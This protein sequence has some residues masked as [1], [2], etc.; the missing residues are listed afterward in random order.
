MK[1]S[2]LRAL[3][4]AF[5]VVF[6]IIF[7]ISLIATIISGV[8]TGLFGAA[9]DGAG[10]A[11][12]GNASNEPNYGGVVIF[13]IFGLSMLMAGSI[14]VIGIILLI[15]SALILVA[16]ILIIT[17]DPD[18]AFVEASD[19]IKLLIAMVIFGLLAIAFIVFPIVTKTAYL[20]SVC[21][22]ALF[23]FAAYYSWGSYREISI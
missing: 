4:Y 20:I 12:N 3:A 5:A 19:K 23:G 6:G 14:A 15:I 17:I 7:V 22:F 9:V 18:E 8:T 2:K 13:L 1:L 10:N 16:S 11:N 21:M